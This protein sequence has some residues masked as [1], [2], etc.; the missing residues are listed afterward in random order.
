MSTLVPVGRATITAAG[1]ASQALLISN[2]LCK[3]YFCVPKS[4]GAATPAAGTTSITWKPAGGDTITLKQSGIAVNMDPT[5]L[6]PFT[7]SCP[8]DAIYFTPS[9][10]T[11]N[12][13]IQIEVYGEVD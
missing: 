9:S 2:K 7:I 5:D 11:A 8:A 4:V 3:K 13:S 10:W 12:S 6:Q 1:G